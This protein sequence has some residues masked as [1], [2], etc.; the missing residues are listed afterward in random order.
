MTQALWVFASN[1]CG[2]YGFVDLTIAHVG[3]TDPVGQI[4]LVSQRKDIDI[5]GGSGMLLRVI[6]S[7]RQLP[8]TL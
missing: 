2:S 3:R 4:V 5:C 8:N 7:T 6:R 1:A